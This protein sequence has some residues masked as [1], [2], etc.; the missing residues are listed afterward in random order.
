MKKHIAEYTDSHFFMIVSSNG[1][2]TRITGP[3]WGNPQVT[4]EFAP[5][6][7]QWRRALMFSWSWTIDI[8]LFWDAIALIK[9]HCNAME[10]SCK[11]LHNDTLLFKNCLDTQVLITAVW[12]MYERF[13]FKFPASFK[14]HLKDVPTIWTEFFFS[15]WAAMAGPFHVTRSRMADVCALKMKLV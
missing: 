3:L 1:N 11:E 14:K 15:F 7:G 12:K 13:F 9:H 2:L 4:G 6:K 5:Q 10:I 8:P